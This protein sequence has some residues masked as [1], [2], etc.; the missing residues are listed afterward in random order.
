[1][2]KIE[3]DATPPNDKYDIVVGNNKPYRLQFVE[4]PKFSHDDPAALDYLTENGYVVYKN[5]ATTEE[6]NK[7]VDLFWQ[8]IERETKSTIRRHDPETWSGSTKY[9]FPGSNGTGVATEYGIGQSEFLWYIR[10]L[11]TI[12]KVF[13]MIWGEDDLLTS[14]DGCGIFRPAEINPLWRTNGSWFHI[15][16]NGNS[17]PERCCIQGLLNLLPG[18]VDD[19]GL[20]V[21]PKSHLIFNDIFRNHQFASGKD[22]VRLSHK[23]IPE[24]WNANCKPTKL[25]VA[26]G[27]FVMWDSRTVHCNH[28]ALILEKKPNPPVLRRLV[29]YV[30]MTPKRFAKKLKPL[31]L[32]RVNAFQRAITSSHWPHEFYPSSRP[33]KSDT[34]VVPQLNEHQIRLL[35]GSDANMNPYDPLPEQK[36]P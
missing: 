31:R 36:E 1:M 2:N 18:G 7:A 19:G 21:I 33:Y 13:Q 6:L 26:P 4:P 11:P 24:L 5:M 15:D 23:N 10:G 9:P 8:H 16:Q 27:D 30:C 12:A 25:I 32:E 29:A 22:F 20:V 14:F 35:V 28:P 34:W 3:T 17:K